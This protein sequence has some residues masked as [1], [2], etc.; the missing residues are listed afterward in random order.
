[1]HRLSEINGEAAQV[2]IEGRHRLGDSAKAGVG[3]LHD[4]PNRHKSLH[5]LGDHRRLGE[6]LAI[7]CELSRYA[8]IA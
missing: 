4:R 5:G 1:M 3:E 8:T 6:P 7:A 2:F